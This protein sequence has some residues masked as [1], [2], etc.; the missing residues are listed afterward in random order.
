MR[1]TGVE[2]SR[3]R[4]ILKNIGLIEFRPLHPAVELQ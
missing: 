3:L 4:R 1:A 2:R